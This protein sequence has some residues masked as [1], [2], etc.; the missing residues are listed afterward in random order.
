MFGQ[1][2]QYFDKSSGLPS[3]NTYQIIQSKDNYL[4]LTTDMGVVRY[5]GTHFTAFDNTDRLKCND[6]YE[7]IKGNN[8]ELLFLGDNGKISHFET[9]ELSNQ[10][11]NTDQLEFNAFVSE[12]ITTQ[13]GRFVASS[14]GDGVK[15]LDNNKVI[16][17][18]KENGLAD[19]HV[20]FIWEN[21]GAIYVLSKEG[22]SKI[23]AR[24]EV[25]IIH[26]FESTIH[27]SR[28]LKFDNGKVLFSGREDLFVLNKDETLTKVKRGNLITI[29]TPT[30]FQ[31]IDNFIYAS[32]YNGVQ[33]FSLPNNE[34]VIHDS[35]LNQ[36]VITSVL[37]DHEGNF[38]ASTLNTGLIKLSDRSITNLSE[39]RQV[40]S[41]FQ[42]QDS[43]LLFG[44]NDWTFGVYENKKITF[45]KID[46]KN[47]FTNQKINGIHQSFGLTWFETDGGTA[48]FDGTNTSFYRTGKGELYFYKNKLYIGNKL[49]CFKINSLKELQPLQENL[50]N[51]QLIN[52][53]AERIFN[54]ET[55]SFTNN[56]NILFIGTTEGLY[57]KNAKDEVKRVFEKELFDK[58][59]DVSA[60]N[61]ELIVCHSYYGLFYSIKNKSIRLKKEQ[62]ISSDFCLKAE[63]YKDYI[64]VAT[65]N[66]ID[67]IDKSSVFGKKLNVKS[68]LK[69][70]TIK[71]FIRNGPKIYVATNTGLYVITAFDKASPSFEIPLQETRFY[72]NSE[73]SSPKKLS[74]LS[75][76]ENNIAIDFNFIA[77]GISQPEK[78]Y[79]LNN[80]P[81]KS[82]NGQLQFN[83]LA[84]GKYDVELKVKGGKNE[85]KTLKYT[86]DIHSPWWSTWWF[87]LC[88]IFVAALVVYIF[89]RVRILTYNRDIVRELL[90]AI[91][92]RIKKEK[93]IIVKDVKD[94]SKTKVILSQLNYIESS[95]NYVTLFLNEDKIVVRAS[96]KEMHEK[97]DET[98]NDFFR[99]HR[100]FVI[101]SKK[102]SA[103]HGDF[104]KI[105]ENKIP[106][107]TNYLATAKEKM[108]ILKSQK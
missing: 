50:P 91:L 78:I 28:A 101:N 96:L 71:D 58:I 36:E 42:S 105:R 2:H 22:V 83:E 68:F 87:R 66:G 9:S 33:I 27:F 46:E 64:I 47:A 48:T 102:V 52:E 43:T 12:F 32:S 15:I 75:Y 82:F 67:I 65:S 100:S 26:H 70:K 108:R 3:N 51:K 25:E 20:S 41:L 80:E 44:L 92:N 10:I 86:I 34:V 54:K 31:L 77:F 37:K 95:K 30:N 88:V 1:D 4:W 98:S 74:S 57:T 69:G 21:K 14:F 84:P 16:S 59:I 29:N 56:K 13:D 35:L 8:H 97:L 63:I 85:S 24:Y 104:F 76:D 81:W 103:V 7:I 39:N 55:I 17:F 38:W 49:G 61:N 107:G 45:N 93:F 23:N 18:N 79:R 19:N 72:I 60:L 99:C 6:N 106:I 89:F 62:G 40:N 90:Q 11:H 53:Y 5:D 73:Q 94:G